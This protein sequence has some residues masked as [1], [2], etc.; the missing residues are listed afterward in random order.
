[1]LDTLA[2]YGVINDRLDEVSNFYR[3]NASR[4]ECWRHNRA[5]AYA[6]VR[7]GVVTG[8]TV[9]DAGYGYSSPPAISVPGFPEVTAKSTLSWSTDFMKN[10]ALKEVRLAGNP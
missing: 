4:G 2:P 3:D 1:L 7:N 5:T 6:T 8:I 10:G 9:T